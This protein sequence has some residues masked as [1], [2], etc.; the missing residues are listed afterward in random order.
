MSSRLITYMH[1]TICFVSV[2]Y[3]YIYRDLFIEKIGYIIG[4]KD[5]IIQNKLDTNDSINHDIDSEYSD[6]SDDLDN[7]ISRYALG[8]Y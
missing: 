8:I 3:I 1:L 6:D 7:D 5:D 2:M 4:D